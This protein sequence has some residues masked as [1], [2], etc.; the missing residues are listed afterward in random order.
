MLNV[1]EKLYGRR[2][3]NLMIIVMPV[4]NISLGVI[5]IFKIETE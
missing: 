4:H 1:V 2:N 3:Y 5:C